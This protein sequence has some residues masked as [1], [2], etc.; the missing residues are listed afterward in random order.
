MVNLRLLGN[1]DFGVAFGLMLMLGFTLLGSTYA[2]PAFVQS[3]LGYPAVDAG[4]VITPGGFAV[5]LMLPIVGALVNKVDL[6]VLIAFGLIVGC[7][8]LWWMTNFYLERLVS[9]SSC[10]H[11]SRNL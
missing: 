5:M 6:R 10:W 1:R 2:I 11:A 7:A 4:L 8:S 3:L 9:R